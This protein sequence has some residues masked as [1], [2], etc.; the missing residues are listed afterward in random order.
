[1][2]KKF[3]NDLFTF[4]L[5]VLAI[6]CFYFSATAVFTSALFNLLLLFLAVFLLIQASGFVDKAKGFGKYAEH[7]HQE[8]HHDKDIPN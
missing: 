5:F 2:M 1:M 7:E 6:I 8:H 4:L 3:L